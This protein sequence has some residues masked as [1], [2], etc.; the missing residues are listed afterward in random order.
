MPGHLKYHQQ[1]FVSLSG[2]EFHNG[3]DEEVIFC[4]MSNPPEDQGVVVDHGHRK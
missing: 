4:C 1:Q 3:G 2:F